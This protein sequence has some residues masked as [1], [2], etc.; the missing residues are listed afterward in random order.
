MAHW[1]RDEREDTGKWYDRGVDWMVKNKSQDQELQR[2]RAEAAELL[3]LK[4][5]QE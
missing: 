5:K 4:E 2:F 3:G 1:Q